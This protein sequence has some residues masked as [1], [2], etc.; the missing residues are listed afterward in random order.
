MEVTLSR[1]SSREGISALVMVII[2]DGLE[3]KVLDRA[4]TSVACVPELGASVVV[5]VTGGGGAKEEEEDDDEEEV[6]G[7][8]RRESFSMGWKDSTAQVPPLHVLTTGAFGYI[9]VGYV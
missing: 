4:S 7:V 9:S 8:V 5:V 6:H 3:G 2:F 1:N